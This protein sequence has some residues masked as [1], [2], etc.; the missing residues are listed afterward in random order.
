V[1]RLGEGAHDGL[2]VKADASGGTITLIYSTGPLLDG[3]LPTAK[4]PLGSFPVKIP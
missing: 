1:A 4:I 3:S 2:S